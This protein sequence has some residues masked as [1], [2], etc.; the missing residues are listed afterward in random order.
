MGDSRGSIGGNSRGSIGGNSRGSNSGNSRGSNMRDGRGSIGGDGR[1]GN[2]NSTVAVERLSISLTLAVVMGPVSSVVSSQTRVAVSGSVSQ[3]VVGPG[4]RV[5][6]APVDT[7]VSEP[8]VSQTM[9]AI[10]VAAV[11]GVSLSISLTLAVVVTPV[12]SIVSNGRVSDRG[13]YPM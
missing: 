10:A 13:Y 2:A 12:S 8:R 4:D 6:V 5:A 3:S 1:G 7:R 11:V 9:V